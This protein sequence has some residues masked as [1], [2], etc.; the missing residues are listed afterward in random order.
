MSTSRKRKI[1]EIEPKISNIIRYPPK[2]VSIKLPTRFKISHAP[3]NNEAIQYNTP[4][5]GKTSRFLSP[6]IYG[7]V[8]QRAKIKIFTPLFHKKSRSECVSRPIARTEPKPMAWE[9]D[10]NEF[11][12]FFD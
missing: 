2:I 8:K 11:H 3:I 4:R 7:K 12:F 9:M 5:L 10:K 6:S 1:Y